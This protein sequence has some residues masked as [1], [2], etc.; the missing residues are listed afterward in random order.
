MLSSTWPCIEG[1]KDVSVC[2]EHGHWQAQW[3]QVITSNRS[4]HQTGHQI[5][6][7]ITSNG[8]SHQIGHQ[9][10]TS[11]RSSHQMPTQQSVPVLVKTESGIWCF[12]V[13][14]GGYLVHVCQLCLILQPL[15]VKQNVCLIL[16]PLPV[17]WTVCFA[18]GR[19]QPCTVSAL[20]IDA[21]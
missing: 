5:K 13:Y 10:I 2:S 20:M 4:S 21:V 9:V 17:K 16:Q 19:I 1:R 18:E 7:V 3:W 12:F 14:V 15:P 6:L 8:S 11:N